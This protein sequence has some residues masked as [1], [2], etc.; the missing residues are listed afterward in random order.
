[1]VGLASIPIK[2][3]LNIKD[4]CVTATKNNLKG[5]ALSGAVL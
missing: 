4:F 5:K 2:Q 1:M 3:K